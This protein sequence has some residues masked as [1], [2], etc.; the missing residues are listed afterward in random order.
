VDLGVVGDARETLRLLVATLRE[1]GASFALDPA[2]RRSLRQDHARYLREMDDVADKKFSVLGGGELLNEAAVA[3]ALRD[4]IPSDAIFCYDGGTAMAWFHTYLQPRDSLSSL[5]NPGMGHL[6]TGLPFANAAKLANPDRPVFCLTGDG[7]FGLTIQELET[8]ARNG[9]NI[10]TVVLNDSH[11]G[12]YR[13]IGE[14]LLHNPNFGTKLTDV[15]YARVAEGFG[16][17]GETVRRLEELVP[18]L[19]RSMEAGKPA[20]VDV[21]VDWTPHGWADEM[22]QSMFFFDVSALAKY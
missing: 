7:A 4:A 22:F 12:M 20:V 17:H 8:S 6:G 19:E 9:L 1:K 2:W 3:R 14:F 16:C 15:D 5:Y 10:V 11:W 18:A 13:S 21:V